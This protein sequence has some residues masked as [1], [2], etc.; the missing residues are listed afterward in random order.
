MRFVMP[1][2]DCSKIKFTQGGFLSPPNTNPP[3]RSF[4]DVRLDPHANVDFPENRVQALN[5]T[6]EKFL[7][8]LFVFR[9]LNKPALE[10][11]D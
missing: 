9:K 7:E 10:K 8:T 3:T 11:V 1:V 5:Y 6:P 2:K 4:S